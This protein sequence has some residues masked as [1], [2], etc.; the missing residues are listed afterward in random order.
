MT[1]KVVIA[2]TMALAHR[3]GNRAG[4]AAKVAR[5]IPVAYSPVIS[6]TPRTPMASWARKMPLR[7]R[8]VGSN[9]AASPGVP[10]RPVR[11]RHGRNQHGQPDDEHDGCEQ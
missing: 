9:A 7:L 8:V 10:R 6:R 1:A 2:N 11:H 4:T 3:T 5:I